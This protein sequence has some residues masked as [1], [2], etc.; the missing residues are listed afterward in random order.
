MVRWLS[1]HAPTPGTPV[2][3]L[4]WELRSCKLHSTDKKQINIGDTSNRG[5]TC[6]VD[7]AIN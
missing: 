6:T 2:P 4:I 1:P 3:S 7:H 5:I